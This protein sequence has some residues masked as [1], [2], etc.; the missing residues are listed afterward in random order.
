MKPAD[1]NEKDSLNLINEMMHTARREQPAHAPFYLVMWGLIVIAFSLVNF[2][3]VRNTGTIQ[4]L[5]YNLFA[6]GGLLSWWYSRKTDKE[7]KTV[8]WYNSLYVFV[9]SGVGICLALIWSFVPVLGIHNIIPSILMVYALAS[10]I[11][12]GVTKYRPSIFGACVCFVC[13]IFAFG[14]SFAYQ[15]LVM[16]VAVMAAHVIPGLMMRRHYKG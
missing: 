5:A 13:V 2:F 12:G 6:L 4:P 3:S 7:E 8:S 15:Y 11:T 9:W 16:A 14:V 1:F 10:Y